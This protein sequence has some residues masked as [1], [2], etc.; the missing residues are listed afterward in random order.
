MI[1]GTE[2]SNIICWVW[3]PE[4][5]TSEMVFVLVQS[6]TSQHLDEWA[7]AYLTIACGTDYQGR[8]RSWGRDIVEKG[9]KELGLR[10]EKVQKIDKKG[11]SASS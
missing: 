6:V 9:M 8:D 4:L 11:D 3:S 7:A 10:E 5:L 2:S 1:G